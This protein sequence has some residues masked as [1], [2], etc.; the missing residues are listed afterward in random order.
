MLCSCDTF[1]VR[2]V[3]VKW[4]CENKAILRGHLFNTKNKHTKSFMSKL[5]HPVLLRLFTIHLDG[6]SGKKL[7][8]LCLQLLYHFHQSSL[9][10]DGR[11]CGIGNPQ[12]YQDQEHHVREVADC[13]GNY[14][15]DLMK[16]W[17]IVYGT[18]AG[19]LAVCSFCNEVLKRI[20]WRVLSALHLSNLVENWFSIC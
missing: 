10:I 14:Q 13:Q 3:C 19:G 7:E 8:H 18:I 17:Q 5:I 12:E 1:F 4:P 9:Q 16:T 2:V 11:W 6:Q 15:M 20:M